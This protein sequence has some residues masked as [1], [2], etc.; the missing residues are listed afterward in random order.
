MFFNSTFFKLIIFFIDIRI[1]FINIF[2]INFC[3]LNA[4]IFL[5]SCLPNT[6]DGYFSQL[7]LIDPTSD[8]II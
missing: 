7:N 4:S 8:L 5:V 2:L 1:N 6:F 3:I